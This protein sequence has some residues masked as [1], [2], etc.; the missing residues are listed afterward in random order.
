MRIRGRKHRRRTCVFGAAAALALAS[1]GA[2]TVVD[3]AYP[4][5]AGSGEASAADARRL[6]AKDA[7]PPCAL[8]HTMKHAGATGE[9]GPS[10][11][12][13]RPDA[14]RVITVI[15]NGIGQMPAY[16]SLSEKE[17]EAIAHYVARYSGGN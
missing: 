4:A 11:D 3:S 16:T 6:F 7:V 2:G 17:I 8:C 15:R 14:Q 5:Y 1:A 10:L 9:I 12:E 13:L